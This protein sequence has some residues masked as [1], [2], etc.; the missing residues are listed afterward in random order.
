MYEEWSTQFFLMCIKLL[1]GVNPFLILIVLWSCR[2]LQEIKNN[3]ISW[4][5]VFSFVP[6]IHAMGS[7][8]PVKIFEPVQ[9][10]DLDL[11]L[12]WE[13]T[14]GQDW[15][16]VFFLSNFLPIIRP[17]KGS[18]FTPL[19]WISSNNFVNLIITGFQ[20]ENCKE[21]DDKYVPI[22]MDRDKTICYQTF[23]SNGH[24]YKM[25]FISYSFNWGQSSI[26][27]LHRIIYRKQIYFIFSVCLLHSEK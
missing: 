16:N 2:H 5:Y 7:L 23:Q 10:Q 3:K 21:L 11:Q 19:N 17:G 20:P 25:V 26:V 27:F 12:K 18:I 15:W 22:Y 24:K 4:K 14:V 1:A 9:S 6:V 8:N 13:M